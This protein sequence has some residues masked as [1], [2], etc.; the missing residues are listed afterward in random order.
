MESAYVRYLRTCRFVFAKLTR[1]FVLRKQINACVN[2]IR[3]H[4]P[5]RNLYISH[6][7][8]V[9]GFRISVHQLKLADHLDVDCYVCG[10]HAPQ[11]WFVLTLI[12]II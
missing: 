10:L 11:L 6:T 3:Q 4:F 2:T 1:S 7:T 12:N 8:V 5:L 9:Q